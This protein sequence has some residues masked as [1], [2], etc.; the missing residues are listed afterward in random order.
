MVGGFVADVGGGFRVVG[1]GPEGKELPVGQH[2]VQGF[3]LSANELHSVG[4]A[5]VEAAHS[6][7]EGGV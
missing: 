7:A 3:Q 1:G 5:G 4:A 2:V 6:G